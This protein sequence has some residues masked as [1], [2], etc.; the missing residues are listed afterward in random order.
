[1][2]SQEFSVRRLLTL[3]EVIALSGLSRST[4]YRRLAAGDDFPVP[5]RT[6]WQKSARRLG[7]DSR[8]VEAWLDSRPAASL[9]GP[10]LTVPRRER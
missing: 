5:V 3:K 8:D 6:G 10:S 9:H 2:A 7:W 1:M 4:I